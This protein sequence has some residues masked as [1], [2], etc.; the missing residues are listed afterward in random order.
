MEAALIGLYL[1]P[2]LIAV[3]R[4]DRSM[5]SIAVLNIFLGWTFIFWVITLAMALR[6]HRGARKAC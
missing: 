1:L 5:D 3:L 2:T 6:H 4:R